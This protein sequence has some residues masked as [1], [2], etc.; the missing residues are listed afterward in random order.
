MTGFKRQLLDRIHAARE[1]AI[2]FFDGLKD[3][4]CGWRYTATHD[5]IAYP[6]ATLYGTW[7]AILGQVLLKRTQEWS[8]TEKK[9]AIKKIANHQQKDGC[10][11]ARGLGDTRIDKSREYMILHCT[12][13]S[14][15]AI[16]ELD[17]D[18]DFQIPYM[19]RFLDAD[20]LAA[21][22]DARSLSRPYEEGNN[23]VNVMA[24]LA[25]CHERGVPAAFERLSQALEWHQKAQNP[26]T[27]G[28]DCFTSPVLDQRIQSLAGAAHNYHLYYYVNEP[29]RYGEAVAEVLPLL[30]TAGQLKACFTIDFVELAIRVLPAAPNPQ[31]LVWA[32]LYHAAVLLNFQRPDG[33]WQEGA[34][35]RSPSVGAGF[36]DT[37]VSSSS[38]AT[39]FRL[40]ALGMIAITLLEDDAENWG[41]RSTLGSGYAPKSWPTLPDHVQVEPGSLAFKVPLK[42]RHFSRG[43]SQFFSRACSKTSRLIFG[44]F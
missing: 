13:Y 29:L 22:L 43:A 5:T 25:L 44:E 37:V 18:F 1:K 19:E 31:Q 24:Y 40:A 14:H 20:F 41:F 16:L 11:L 32:L 36:K 12:N 21:W 15:G 6:A 23:I 7:S 17:P 30:L 10:F 27:G 4:V 9:W 28:F 42:H 26:V 3:E 35:L 2:S 8:V 33:G 38:Y 34:D 39:W